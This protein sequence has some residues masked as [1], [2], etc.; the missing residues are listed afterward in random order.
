MGNVYLVYHVRLNRQLALK[1]LVRITDTLERQRQFEEQ[2]EMEAQILASLDHPNLASVNDYF[3]ERGNHYLVMEFIDGRTLTEIVSLAP[4]TISERRVLAWAGELCDV[5]EYLHGQS[6]PVIVRDL[7]PDNVMLSLSDRKLR[8]I[9]FGIAKQAPEAVGTQPIVKGVGTPEYA[10]LEQY[11]NS[12]TDARSDLYSLGATL[13]F[14]L[15]GKAPPPAFK[16]GQSDARLHDPREV[17]PTVSAQTWSA[18]QALMSLHPEGRPSS[19]HQ[20]RQL[21]GV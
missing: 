4:K 16:R 17:N 8:L 7:K 21:L 18:I 5:L 14:L 13:L 1:E 6:P 19:A 9:D 2:F 20:A 11:G 15:S 12:N 3:L 10:P